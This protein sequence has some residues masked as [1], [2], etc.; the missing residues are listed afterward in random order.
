[1]Q[2]NSGGIK[3]TFS[4]VQIEYIFYLVASLLMIW[5]HM[6]T[7][8]RDPGFIPKGYRYDENNLV[9][10]YSTYANKLSIRKRK[11]DEELRQSEA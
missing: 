10:P 5:S 1:M 2:S 7:M 8:C 3:W 6:A 4:S 11:D 9:K